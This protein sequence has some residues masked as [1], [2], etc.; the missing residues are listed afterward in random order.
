MHCHRNPSTWHH[1]AFDNGKLYV[2]DPQ[3]GKSYI[4]HP[5]DRG[6]WAHWDGDGSDDDTFPP[7]C[8]KPRP[9]QKRAPYNGQSLTDPNG[10]GQ[11]W[12]PPFGTPFLPLIE[13]PLPGLPATNFGGALEPFFVP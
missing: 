4:L 9:G 5:E 2:E 10:N 6:H 8:R 7:N 1:G 3:S 12:K 11:R 13:G